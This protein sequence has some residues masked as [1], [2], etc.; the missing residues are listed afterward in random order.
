[1]KWY[2]KCLP[3]T[4]P[5]FDSRS[6]DVSGKTHPWLCVAKGC[7]TAILDGRPLLQ[8]EAAAPPSSYSSVVRVSVLS[9]ECR[10][11]EPVYEHARITQLVECRS[12][13]PVV[14]SSNLPTSTFRAD[15]W[16]NIWLVY[17][18]FFRGRLLS[19][20]NKTLSVVRV[21]E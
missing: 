13:K 9:T 6:G 8:P 3:H 11:F 14:G 18:C 15:S 4:L 2:H 12:N 16:S 1:M 19:H 5:E 7:E 21:G 10:Q 17:S 20:S